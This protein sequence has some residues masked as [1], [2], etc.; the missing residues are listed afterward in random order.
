[1]Y[2]TSFDYVYV[3]AEFSLYFDKINEPGE[4]YSPRQFKV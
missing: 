3:S 2:R 1:M 4:D